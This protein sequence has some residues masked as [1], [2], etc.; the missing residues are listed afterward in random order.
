MMRTRQPFDPPWEPFLI[1]FKAAAATRHA[2]W[3]TRRGDILTTR[4]TGHCP[5]LSAKSSKIK[6]QNSRST[7]PGAL[8]FTSYVIKSKAAAATLSA[9]WG[10][11]RGRLLTTPHTG[12][13][14][15]RWTNNSKL[16]NKTT[17]QSCARRSVPRC[18]TPGGWS[19]VKLSVSKWI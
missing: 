18:E 16:K 4:C 11:R 13:C 14:P 5:E 7:P 12:H 10:T 6:K 17:L 9:E 2:G 3:G 19:E 15:E 1:N 8:P